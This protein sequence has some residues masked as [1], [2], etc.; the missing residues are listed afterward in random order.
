MLSYLIIWVYVFYFYSR[1]IV[2]LIRGLVVVIIFVCVLV[3][4]SLL[5]TRRKL[6]YCV[7]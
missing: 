3:K 1:H 4:I 2:S 7:S 5:G 6:D